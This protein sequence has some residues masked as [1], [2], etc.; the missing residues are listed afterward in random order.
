MRTA[1]R[2]LLAILLTLAFASP[3]SAA[4]PWRRV[5]RT[6]VRASDGVRIALYRYAPADGGRGDATVLLFPDV[7]MTHRAYD[8]EGRGLARYLQRRGVEVFVAEFR[9]GG[10]SDV[11]FG[12]CD[13]DDLVNGDGEAALAQVQARL[14]A[15]GLQRKVYLG[16][17]GLGGTVAMVLAG[18]HPQQVR[19]V[20]GLQAAMT[21]DVPNEPLA[22]SMS[23]L[24]SAPRWIDLAGLSAQPLFD[25]TW[26]E[27][28][29]A[30]DGSIHRERAERMRT[31]LLTTVS[32]RLAAQLASF[33]RRREILVGGED[34]RATI[35]A[36]RGPS[37]LVFA[38]RDNWIHPEFATPARDLLD[39][40]QM[41][42]RVLTRLESAA[43]D[44]G[45]L[46]MLLGSRAE[47]DVFAP[48]LAFLEPE[49][50]RL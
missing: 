49:E 41:K 23:L 13:F 15:A 17:A 40:S 39:R 28:M 43:V 24:D 47:R 27:L 18:R 5:E 10:W 42:V 35:A 8:F 33:M 1:V 30:N 3:A 37:L 34:V 20:I 48:V 19:G 31:R 45:H 21:L 6:G 29:L 32:D 16:G 26:F 9:G 4:Q 12:G 14:R 46:G 38:P 50:V 7:G 22:A 36:F 25:R 44:Y 2:L 11:P